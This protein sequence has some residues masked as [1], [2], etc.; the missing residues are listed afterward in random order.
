MVCISPQEFLSPKIKAF[1]DR[2]FNG[3]SNHIESI[4]GES[5]IRD[6]VIKCRIYL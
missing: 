2:S 3:A 6:R 4:I 1:D 5:Q